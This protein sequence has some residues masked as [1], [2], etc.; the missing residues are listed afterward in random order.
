[1]SAREPRESDDRHSVD[2][3]HLEVL[4]GAE[5]R[6]RQRDRRSARGASPA[7]SGFRRTQYLA[8]RVVR[9]R[10]KVRASTDQ[11]R[12]HRDAGPRGRPRAT[13]VTA[14][15]CPRS[16]RAGG[17]AVR[18]GLP[19]WQFLPCNSGITVAKL[20]MLDRRVR[21]QSTVASTEGR[22]QA[23]R[24]HRTPRVYQGPS[25]LF[26]SYGST[27]FFRSGSLSATER[28]ARRRQVLLSNRT[29]I[30]PGARALG[31]AG[32]SHQQGE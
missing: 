26:R 7:S 3:E 28:D 14:P 22:R 5:T 9:G 21:G 1:L 6:S 24:F 10:A 29:P 20:T 25:L 4:G 8:S 18:P 2:V 17:C 12:A 32:R 16:R 11:C 15:R 30:R 27:R 13:G 19:A 31:H 23:V